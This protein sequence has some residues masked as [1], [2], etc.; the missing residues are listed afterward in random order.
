[1]QSPMHDHRG[2]TRL[3]ASLMFRRPIR[4]GGVSGRGQGAVVSS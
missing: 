3:T 4:V 1:M 2:H